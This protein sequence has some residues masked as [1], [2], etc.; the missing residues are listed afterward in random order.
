M[1]EE[2]RRIDTAY[3]RFFN[4]LGGKPKRKPKHKFKSITYPGQAG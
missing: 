4:K 3:Q 2:L 1:Q